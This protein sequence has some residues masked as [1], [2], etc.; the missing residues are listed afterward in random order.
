[1]VAEGGEGRAA[2]HTLSRMNPRM[3]LLSSLAHTTNTS[4]MGELVI[5]FL[6]PF[7]M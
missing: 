2:A 7:R 5:Q 1:M 6:E 4:A 3:S